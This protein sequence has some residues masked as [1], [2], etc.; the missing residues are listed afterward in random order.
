LKGRICAAGFGFAEKK[1]IAFTFWIPASVF[2]GIIVASQ[3]L[4][5]HTI[6]ELLLKRELWWIVHGY[7]RR[8]ILL[9]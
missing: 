6:I 1:M 7:T 5:R 2:H 9:F 3:S 8:R 4:W